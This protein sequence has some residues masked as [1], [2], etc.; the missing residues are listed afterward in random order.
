MSPF[1][2]EAFLLGIYLEVKGLNCGEIIFSTLLDINKP[3]SKKVVLID[4]PPAGSENARFCTFSLTL[5]IRVFRFWYFKGIYF[6]PMKAM[7][8]SSTPAN[9]LH[10]PDLCNVTQLSEHHESHLLCQECIYGL[11]VANSYSFIKSQ[12][13]CPCLCGTFS[14]SHRSFIVPS[15]CPHSSVYRSHLLHWWCYIIITFCG[16]FHHWTMRFSRAGM[17]NKRLNSWASLVLT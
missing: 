4:I 15:H 2:R 8:Q 11:G 1:A 14:D 13:K 3:S 9:V 6:W 7:S 10:A 12:L 17:I 16:S 5:G